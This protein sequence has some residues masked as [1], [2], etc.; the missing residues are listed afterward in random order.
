MS[1]T[2]TRFACAIAGVF[3]FTGVAAAQPAP[4]PPKPG[5]PVKVDVVLSRYLGEKKTS[6][7]PFTIWVNVG[8]R[9][10][11]SGSVRMGVDVPVGSKTTTNSVPN[12]VVDPKATTASTTSAM[13]YRN[14]GTSVDANMQLAA[15]GKFSVNVRVQDSSIYTSPSSGRGVPRLVDPL[16]FR[17]FSM[18]NRM[19][20]RDGQTLEFAVA[21]DK[22][23]GETVK[24]DV[25]LNVVK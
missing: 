21:T 17:T 3:L 5:I 4:N 7:L 6:S 15:E 9:G 13:E 23:S 19:E 12:P 10:G 24:V 18:D 1:M 20:M 8:D 25:T 2:G 11:G 14:V 16:A 22:V